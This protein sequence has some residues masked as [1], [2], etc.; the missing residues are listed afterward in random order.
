M[1]FYTIFI[2]KLFRD[3][4]FIMYINI[5]INFINYNNIY[6]FIIKFIFINNH[7]LLTFAT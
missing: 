5:K 3:D 7:N 6:L 2:Y 1:I 4:Y